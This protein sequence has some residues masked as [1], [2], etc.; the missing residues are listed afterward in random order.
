MNIQG[1]LKAI[2]GAIA[3]ALGATQVAY[4]SAGHI[5]LK[6]GIGIAITFWGALAVIWAVPNANPTKPNP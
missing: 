4:L 1:Y 6:E 2:Y 3:A 5:G